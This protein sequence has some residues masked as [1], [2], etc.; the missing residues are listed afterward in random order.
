MQKLYFILLGFLFL[1]N[2][3]AQKRNEPCG[4][5]FSMLVQPGTIPVDENGNHIKPKINKERFIYIMVPGKTKPVIKAVSYNKTIVKWEI[6]N[7]PENEYSPV[8]E[9]TQNAM[10]IKPAKNA[11]MWR[12]NIQ[13]SANHPIETK[14]VPIVI[15][16][17]VQT[18]PFTVV[19]LKET[20]VQGYDTY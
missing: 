6:L 4:Y 14:A 16:G 20:A 12:I 7:L 3:V 1:Q 10:R 2:A 15:K 11:T 13:E 9:T 17:T 5:A 18:K 8:A 19:I